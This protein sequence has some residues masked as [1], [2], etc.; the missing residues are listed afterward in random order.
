MRT[1]EQDRAV[2]AHEAVKNVKKTEDAKLQKEYGQIC[3]DLPF[4]ILKNGLCQT[5]AY[6]E[7]K[8]HKKRQYELLLEDFAKVCSGAAGPDY[9]KKVREAEVADYQRMTHEALACAQWFKR[10]AEAVLKVVPGD[11]EVQT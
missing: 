1:K 4:L 7:A 8:G 2:A 6:Y 11:A 5:V 10:Y 9:A 3:L